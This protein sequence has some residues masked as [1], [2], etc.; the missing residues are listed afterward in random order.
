MNSWEYVKLFEL[1]VYLLFAPPKSRGTADRYFRNEQTHKSG[2]C[3]ESRYSR[4]KWT[5]IY[6]RWTGCSAIRAGHQRIILL[7]ES[8]PPFQRLPKLWRLITSFAYAVRGVPPELAV[9]L[10]C[11]KNRNS[12]KNSGTPKPTRFGKIP[13]RIKSLQKFFERRNGGLPVNRITSEFISWES[14][15]L[16]MQMCPRRWIWLLRESLTSWESHT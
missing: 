13:Q 6:I 3:G 1:I 14:R 12:R 10:W 2:K 16:H 8:A 11:G 7:R 15:W 5:L 9:G 4:P